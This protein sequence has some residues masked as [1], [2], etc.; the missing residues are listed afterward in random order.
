MSCHCH[1]LKTSSNIL[2]VITG[3]IF[4]CEK[5]LR[6]LVVFL[7]APNCFNQLC[8]H[9]IPF[10]WH[11]VRSL[12]PRVS[13][14]ENVRRQVHSSILRPVIHLFCKFE[15]PPTGRLHVLLRANKRACRQ[16][17]WRATA[18][19]ANAAIKAQSCQW[20]KRWGRTKMVKVAMKSTGLV[21]IKVTV[22]FLVSHLHFTVFPFTACG[23]DVF[24][25]DKYSDLISCW[26]T[27]ETCFQTQLDS[28]K[29][30]SF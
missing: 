16:D 24:F 6:L 4:V 12:G 5:L 30:V 18:D 11:L 21:L 1:H 15:S 14:L 17:F 10:M 2:R 26:A 7:K 13:T 23:N 25:K 27:R 28:G 19:L 8:G 9:S 3:S 20:P 22:W 29:I